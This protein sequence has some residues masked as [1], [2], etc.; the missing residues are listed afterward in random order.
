M[1]IL[2]RYISKEYIRMFL[3]VV[4]S[5]L[6][7]Y[8]IIDFFEKIR[9]FLSNSASFYQIAS[10]F[11]FKLP[12]IISQT[13]PAAV[14]L[15]ALLTFGMLSR[16]SEIVAMKANGVSLYKT[17]FPVIIISIIVCIFTFLFN[18]FITPYANQ[19]A[20]YIKLIEVQKRKKM[21]SFK[22][23]Q[24]WYRSKDAIY[25]FNI[26]DPGTN[27]LKGITINYLDRNFTPSMRID[28][29]EAKWE[30][31]KWVFRNVLV[32]RFPPGG[33]STLERFTTKVVNIPEKPS[34]FKVVQKDAEEMGYLELKNYVKKLQFEGYDSTRYLADLHGK[35]AFPL[36]S[37]IL[38]VIG[39]SFSLKTER[40][41]GITK[42]IGA[43]IVIGFSYWVVFA[44][45]LSLGRSGT[46]PPLLAAWLANI[47]FGS[48]AAVM[49]FR[50]RT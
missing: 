12:M 27:T 40:S 29:K 50:V 25:N 41:G 4:A 33:F 22:Q 11:F 14:L 23:N 34:D 36:V 1:S 39:I 35:I 21:G 15:A 2:D 48:A 43:G 10:Y 45:A 38:A 42:S 9:M 16:H 49:F 8:L 6:S 13:M 19:K 26:F 5:F 18:E 47:I 44:F 3:L 30:N 7:L 46:L 37:I 17:A 31:G 20:E 24:M 32:T 28:A